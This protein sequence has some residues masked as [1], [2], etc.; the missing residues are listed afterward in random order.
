MCKYL[1]LPSSIQPRPSNI[2]LTVQHS[3]PAL[4]G[5]YYSIGVG[6]VNREQGVGPLLDLRVGVALTETLEDSSHPS[7][8]YVCMYV[9]IYICMYACLHVCMYACMYVATCMYVC[10]Y[11]CVHVSVGYLHCMTSLPTS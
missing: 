2:D 9:C 11:V 8:V 10:M 7:G 6:V 1:V 4:V 5:E 3:T